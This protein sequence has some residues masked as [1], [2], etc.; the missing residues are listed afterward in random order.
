MPPGFLW[1]GSPEPGRAPS[2]GSRGI[3]ESQKADESVGCGTGVPPHKIRS[4]EAR[5]SMILLW[6]LVVPLAAGGMSLAVN[7]R[8]AMEKINLSA[9]A[10]VLALAGILVAQVLR[11][12]SVSVWDGFLAA[13]SLSA[14]VVLLTAVVALACSVY[15]VGYFRDG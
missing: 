14:L 10:L 13:D 12:G 3:N 8:A 9:F 4:A 1:G 15:A 5:S 6:I 2:P 7:R 11:D